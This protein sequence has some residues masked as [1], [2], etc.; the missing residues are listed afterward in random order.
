MNALTKATPV[1]ALAVLEKSIDLCANITAYRAQ[2]AQLEVQREAMHRQA[3]QIMR[4]DNQAH[5]QKM[6]K[7][8]KLS[9]GFTQTLDALQKDIDQQ[10]CER[11]DK[12]QTQ[13]DSILNTI[14]STETS[15]TVQLQLTSILGE[16]YKQQSELLQKQLEQQTSNADA[17]YKSFTQFTDTLRDSGSAH[18]FTDVN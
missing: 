10:T 1:V 18:V 12:V 13:I 14:A 5:E 3:D 7:M 15:E 6:T 9:H 8:H 16:L 17:V 2:I 11:L 4:Q